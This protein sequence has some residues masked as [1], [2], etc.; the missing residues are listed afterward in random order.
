MITGSD[1]D[2]D[3][4]PHSIGAVDK[5]FGLDFDWEA[6]RFS[7]T[8]VPDEGTALEAG[9]LDKLS[10]V[11]GVMLDLAR[12]VPE[13]SHPVADKDGIK[14]YTLTREPAEPI[15]FNGRSQSVIKVSYSRGDS[16]RKT[17]LWCAPALQFQPL[18]IE[19]RERDGEITVGRLILLTTG[20]SGSKAPAR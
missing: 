20:P 19:Y 16:G 9:T 12:E 4:Y 3:R 2:A 1:S 8:D 18:R 7:R 15:D 14:R 17:S 13:L 6:G 10:L 5:S 11:L